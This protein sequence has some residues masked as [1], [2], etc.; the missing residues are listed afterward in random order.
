[1]RF[2]PAELPESRKVRL[3]RLYRGSVVK[4]ATRQ[5]LVPIPKQ[6]GDL[7]E[8]LPALNWA[9]QVVESVMLDAVSSDGTDN[10]RGR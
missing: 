3:T 4:P 5:V 10:S 9:S 7:V 8:G 6:D 1:M 2:H